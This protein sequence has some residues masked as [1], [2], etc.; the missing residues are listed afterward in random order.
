V[1]NASDT[2]WNTKP[3][4]PA[5]EDNLGIARNSGM[6][7]ACASVRPGRIGNAAWRWF[8]TS[9]CHLSAALQCGLQK[10][11]VTQSLS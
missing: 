8:E 3:V 9:A 10:S 1:L 4:F 5:H 2:L 11:Q 6:A 7:Q